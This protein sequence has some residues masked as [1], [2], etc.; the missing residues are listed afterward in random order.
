MNDSVLSSV[1]IDFLGTKIQGKV[2]D[3]YDLGEQLVIITTDRLSAFD[4][5][6]GCVPFKGQVLNQL[7]A[8]W[9]QQLADIIPNHLITVPDPNVTLAQKCTPLP[10]EVVV[11]GFISGV[12]NTSLWYR[13]SLGERTIY[14][15]DFPDG[16]KK[17]EPLPHAIITPTTKARDGG[18]DERI[19]SDEVIEQGLVEEGLWLEVCQKAI[20]IFQKGQSIAQRGGLMLVDTKYEFGLSEE[21]QLMLIDE[22]H[23][24]DS[25]RFWNSETYVEQMT[26]G[27]EPDNLDK[28]FIRLHYE[29]LGYKGEGE[30]PAMPITL[31][32]EAS[33]R[34][35]QS[36]EMLTGKPFNRGT[37][38]ASA[39][40][41]ENL[42][43][44]IG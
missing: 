39:R 12:T 1:D 42:K 37:L 14:G 3:I 11:R 20:A 17:N 29:A 41:A 24:P 18:H 22:V 4:R 6:L 16:L 25:S 30:P 38:P 26:K 31:A 33:E 40:I 8:F 43:K 19:T 9:F 23:T 10:V 28:E 21:G 2:R 5:V 44:L 32:T 27:L 7:S 13:Y 15:H 36:Y 34:Y 35:I